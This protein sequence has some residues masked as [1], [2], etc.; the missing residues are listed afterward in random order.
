MEISK[1]SA[2]GSEDVDVI[3]EKWKKQIDEQKKRDK[4][5]KYVLNGLKLAALIFL[6]TAI[7][8][9]VI[10]AKNNELDKLQSYASTV[11]TVKVLIVMFS[12]C[13]ALI[14]VLDNLGGTAMTYFCRN[15]IMYDKLDIRSYA[16]E[17]CGIF[18]DVAAV[19]I[20][21]SAEYWIEFPRAKIFEII[22][23]VVCAVTE[24]LFAVFA[25]ILVTAII[26]ASMKSGRLDID[27][28]A[29]SLTVIIMCI[30]SLI[31]SVVIETAF[32]FTVKKRMKTWVDG[33]LEVA[34]KDAG[35][36]KA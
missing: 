20:F 23:S 14:K 31:V 10:W 26:S 33:V 8:S 36:G 18:K 17:N 32:C 27:V 25:G 35:K 11:N 5:K 30:V 21:F 34:A 19:M 1:E 28:E 12:V 16:K 24:I 2:Q 29:M 6:V 22:K 3:A 9:V 4:I 7:I 15:A 13:A